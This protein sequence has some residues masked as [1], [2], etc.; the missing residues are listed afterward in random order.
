MKLRQAFKRSKEKKFVNKSKSLGLVLISALLLMAIVSGVKAQGTAT[1]VVLDTIG[2]TVNPNG[3]NTYADGT[4][5]TLTATPTSSAYLFA[6]WIISS[7]SGDT[8]STSNPLTLNVVGGDTYAVQAE[9]DPVEP[10]PPGVALPTNMA[11]AA[12]VVVLAAAGGTTSP[13]AG[14]YALEDASAL[15][16]T[17]TAN[18]GWQFSHWTISGAS[19]DHGGAPVNLTPT[20][21]PYSVDHGYGYTYY[22]QPVFTPTGSSEPTPTG[23]TPTPTPGGGMGGL[24]NDQ[25]IIIGLII[26]IVVILIGFG[27]FAMRKK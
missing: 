10:A 22:Y 5:V 7:D 20:D 15:T 26:A 14:T 3:T 17:A 23:A 9:F 6:R 2:G 13:A 24:T 8:T 18:S 21:N 19:I 11:T 27:I 1:V 25:W 4:A 12:I 16:L